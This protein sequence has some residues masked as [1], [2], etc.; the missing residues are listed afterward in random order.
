MRIMATGHRPKKLPGAYNCTH[1]PNLNIIYWISRQLSKIKYSYSEKA[2]ACTGMA[3]GVDQM[4]ANT[5]LS[6]GINYTAFLPCISQSKKWPEASKSLYK[7]LLKKSSE[8]KL[9]NQGPYYEGC[10]QE[11][12]LA[13]RDWA[14]E[15][16][17]RILLAVW[18]G[19]PGGTANMI[20]ACKAKK[21]QTIILEVKDDTDNS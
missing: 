10:M 6:L 15:D 9:V 8:I 2:I 5:C 1:P 17:N 14:L 21:I 7:S 4:F 3:L 11:R 20:K 19:S 18:D 12:N 13:M 16:R